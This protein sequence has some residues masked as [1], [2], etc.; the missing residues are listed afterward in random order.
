MIEFRRREEKMD[1]S[2]LTKLLN[3][4]KEKLL[5]YLEQEGEDGRSGLLNVCLALKEEQ[6]F[7]S[8]QTLDS[9]ITLIKKLAEDP[10]GLLEFAIYR[11]LGTD[12]ERIARIYYGRNTHHWVADGIW[13][14]PGHSPD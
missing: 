1:N 9:S 14:G 10:V 3:E 13:Q 11:K 12:E 8:N 6:D 2:S 7:H 5:V 4:V